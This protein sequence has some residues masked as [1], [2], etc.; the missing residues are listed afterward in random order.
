MTTKTRPASLKKRRVVRCKC[1]K[2]ERVV[3]SLNNADHKMIVYCPDCMPK[4]KSNP[5]R[6]R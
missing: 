5:A 3:L 6:P 2:I 1:G 4:T